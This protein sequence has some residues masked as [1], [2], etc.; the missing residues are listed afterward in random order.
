MTAA[1]TP[2][3]NPSPTPDVCAQG[4]NVAEI[5]AHVSLWTTPP[6]LPKLTFMHWVPS[7]KCKANVA[8]LTSTYY[9]F[10]LCWV[11]HPQSKQKK[12]HT[13]C[14]VT[15]SQLALLALLT[16]VHNTFP[17]LPRLNVL[18]LQATPASCLCLSYTRLRWHCSDGNCRP[19]AGPRE[20]LG[21]LVFTSPMAL[22]CCPH[23]GS[24]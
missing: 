12:V 23:E 6:E 18:C 5:T 4:C 7:L 16:A 9:I 3:A 21:H 17:G 15:Q 13:P 20:P 1:N 24:H 14:H 8:S 11:H 22:T 2:Q 19:P 10:T